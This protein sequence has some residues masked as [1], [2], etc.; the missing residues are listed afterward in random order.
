VKGIF[1]SNFLVKIVFK[2]NL[3]PSKRYFKNSD[4]VENVQKIFFVIN[5]FMCKKFFFVLRYDDFVL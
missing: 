5:R 1:A 2:K 4:F 3:Y